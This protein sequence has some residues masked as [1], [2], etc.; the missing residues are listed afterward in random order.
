MRT[1]PFVLA[2]LLAVLSGLM[3]QAAPT[4]LQNVYARTSINLNGSWN[5]IVDPFDNGFYNYRMAV[6]HGGFG[7]NQQ[8][9]SPSE[10]VEYNFE[11]SPVLRVPGDWNTQSDQFFYYEGSM[12]FKKDFTYEPAAGRRQ[13]LYFGAA[14][15]L[16]NV[17]LNGKYLGEHIGGFTPFSFDVTGKVKPGKNFVVVRVNNTRHAEDVPTV[18]FD[19]WNYGGITRDVLLVDVPT[20]FVDDYS[21]KLA[22]GSYDKLEGSVKLNEA[23]AGESVTFS[24]P[25]LKLTTT[26]TTDAEGKASF[27]LPVK[28]LKLWSPES[29]SLYNLQVTHNG[30]ILND[31]VGFRQIETV[32]K[33]IRLNGKKVF[34]KGISIHEEAPFR[35]GRAY[36]KED[37][38][39]LLGWAKE[40]GCNFVRLAHYP[41]NEHMVR[42][43]EEMGLM[44]WSEIPVYWTIAW[45][46]PGTYTNAAKQLE[47]MID[48]D[49]NR[50]A[51]VVWS[52][53]NE[54]PHS[55]ARKTFLGKLAGLA[56]S[57]DNSRLIS[58]AMEVSDGGR[59][60]SKV[61]DEMNEYVDIVSFNEY[62][63]WYSG[64]PEICKNRTFTIP[65]DKPVFVSEFGG[66]ALQG[67]HGD[68]TARFTEEY[69]EW[70]YRNNLE[71]LDKI[72]GFAGCSPWILMDFRSPRRQLPNVQDFFNRKG[73]ISERGI[74]KKAF[75][76]L[77]DYYNS[78][79]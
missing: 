19:W 13:F 61:Q 60:V 54:T 20:V 24:L 15:Y 23:K 74:K 78:K 25:E 69:Q 12:W 14:N 70:M 41:H 1:K 27:S 72:D 57:K 16:C 38:A 79:P 73:L 8:A 50:C 65:Y 21:L 46:N 33:E 67:M 40:M 71:M 37:A 32:G 58:M 75:Y 44:V 7:T 48:R 56:R 55:E 11:T 63:G 42:M 34:L 64:T 35:Q 39:V 18:N 51:I 5:Y 52:I 47:D 29:P 6:N 59:D 3:L 28:K 76:V 30:E 43:A 49:H 68:S 66:G 17:Y 2:V 62:M 10:L 53:A 36:S 22:K 4:V 26:V 77:R 9:K 45:T 31:R